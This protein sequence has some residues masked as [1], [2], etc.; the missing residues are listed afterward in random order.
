MRESVMPCVD[1][2]G[3]ASQA[4]KLLIV[5]IEM[6]LRWTDLPLKIKD[7][8]EVDNSSKGEQ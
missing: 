3:V 4:T 6:H 8:E 5:P 1:V 2:L 7:V